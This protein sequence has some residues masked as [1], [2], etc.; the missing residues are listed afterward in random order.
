MEL[1]HGGLETGSCTRLG[2]GEKERRRERTEE[3]GKK[4]GSIG[5]DMRVREEKM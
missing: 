3:K 5:I 2:Q 1:R 4:L